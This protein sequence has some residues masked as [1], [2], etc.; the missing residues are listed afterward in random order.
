[1]LESAVYDERRLPGNAY[2]GKAEPRGAQARE[3]VR[4]GLSGELGEQ[5]SLVRPGHEQ[6]RGVQLGLLSN[7]LIR[8]DEAWPGVG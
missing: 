8:A 4:V 7:R 5:V 3:D 6:A 1:V 2:L